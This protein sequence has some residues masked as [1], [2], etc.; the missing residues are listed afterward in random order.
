MAITVAT[1]VRAVN[2]CGSAYDVPMLSGIRKVRHGRTRWCRDLGAA[3]C[4]EEVPK[5]DAIPRVAG[6]K[7]CGFADL[8]RDATLGGRGSG[9]TLRAGIAQKNDAIL[10]RAAGNCGFPA[11]MEGEHRDQKERS[12]AVYCM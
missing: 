3:L 7:M 8:G 6:K 2:G 11:G 5:Y 10:A 4:A 1:R 12:P 9:A